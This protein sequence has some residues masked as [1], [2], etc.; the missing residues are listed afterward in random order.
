MELNRRPYE[1]CIKNTELSNRIKVR[2]EVDYKYVPD[3]YSEE[4][5]AEVYSI[6]FDEIQNLIQN[7][8]ENEKNV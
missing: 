3:E 2:I 5:L 1:K 6:L 7:E 8:N 4:R